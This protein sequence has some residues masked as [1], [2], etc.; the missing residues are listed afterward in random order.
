MLEAMIPP[1]DTTDT[2]KVAA[3]TQASHQLRTYTGMSYHDIFTKGTQHGTSTW[4]GAE[5]YNFRSIEHIRVVR[6][7]FSLH[8]FAILLKDKWRLASTRLTS[9]LKTGSAEPACAAREV[10]LTRLYASASADSCCCC[11]LRQN[12]HTASG[13][14]QWRTRANTCILCGVARCE[15]DRQLAARSTA[16]QASVSGRLA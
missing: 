10:M 1:A 2:S 5:L 3:C 9:A 15:E 11:D 14:Q 16:A 4:V 13:E 7:S 6:K 8:A 12:D